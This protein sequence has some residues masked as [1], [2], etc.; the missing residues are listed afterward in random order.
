MS[1]LIAVAF[2]Q[3]GRAAQVRKR[4]RELN[5]EHQVDVQDLIVVERDAMGTIHVQHGVDGTTPA[6]DER[7]SFWRALVGFFLLEPLED[8]TPHPDDTRGAPRNFDD[9]FAQQLAARITPGTSAILL[10]LDAAEPARLITALAPF[11]GHLLRTS[12]P[13]DLAARLAQMLAAVK[14]S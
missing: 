3:P 2:D 9:A 10:R 7:V 12:L 6:N 11:G 8:L 14:R 13:P 1:Q 5:D 4:M